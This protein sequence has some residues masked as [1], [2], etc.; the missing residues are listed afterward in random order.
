MQPFGGSV[1]TA[2][3]TPDQD[4]GTAQSDQQGNRPHR[5]MTPEGRRTLA[6]CPVPSAEHGNVEVKHRRG[7]ADEVQHARKRDHAVRE[8]AELLH[9][10]EAFQE[11]PQASAQD[12]SGMLDEHGHRAKQ[13]PE[14]V[15]DRQVAGELR[16]QHA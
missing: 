12:V 10:G 4:R 2:A 11:P 13:C 15:R 1:N 9:E 7:E 3:D 14:D 16:R 6:G 5:V 8:V